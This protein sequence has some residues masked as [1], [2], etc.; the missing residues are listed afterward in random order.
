MFD[1]TKA[2][3]GKK[4]P[5]IDSRTLRLAKYLTAVPPPPASCDW[6]KGVTE[7]GM[8]LNDALGD[9]T[10]A[11][12]GHGIQVANLNGDVEVTPQDAVILALYEGA[13]GYVPSD[14]ST[15]QG[16]VIVDVLNFARKWHAGT[17]H[18]HHHQR[19]FRLLAYA[20]P[21]PGD[22]EHVKQAVALFGTV[23]IGLQLPITAQNQVGGVWDV[24]GNPQ[25]DPNSQPGSWGGHSVIVCAYDA[26]GLTCITWGQN[27]RMTWKFWSAYV[28]ESHAVLFHSWLNRF[29]PDMWAAIE[30]DIALVA[31]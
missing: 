29:N 12:I 17:E 13:C 18:A 21:D 4:A 8:M 25:T 15:D 31:G 5:K 27:Q 19:K 22:V 9:C 2:K 7:W 10:C 14:P 23:D 3:L 28:D 30:K 6:T 24:V 16:G 1:H 20:D 11:A 26:D